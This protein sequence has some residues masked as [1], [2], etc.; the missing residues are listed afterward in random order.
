VAVR[1]RNITAEG[2]G[3]KAAEDDNEDNVLRHES[4]SETE[5]RGNKAAEDDG[6]DR[7]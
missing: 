2:R 6:G 4:K 5:G 7:E 1:E 3:N